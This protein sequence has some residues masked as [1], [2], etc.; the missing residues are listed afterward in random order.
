MDSGLLAQLHR[1]CDQLQLTLSPAQ[2]EKLVS[3]IVLLD[4]W[5]KVYNLTSVRDPQQMISRHILDSLAILPYLTGHTLLDV[6]T[7]R[8]CRVFL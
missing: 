6:G 7:G 2:L 4:K 8:A 5:N 3:Y 1:G